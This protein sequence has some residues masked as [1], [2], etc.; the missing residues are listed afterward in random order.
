MA[1]KP[2]ETLR[3]RKVIPAA[4]ERVFKAWIDPAQVKK[5]WS[6]GEGW[7]TPVAEVDLRVGGRFS[8]GNEPSG[9]GVVLITG[10]FLAVDPPDKLVYTWRFPGARPEESRVTVEFNDLGEQTEVVVT[11]EEIG[12][13]MME[14]A[15][16][17]W[18]DALE[19]LGRFVADRS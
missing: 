11:H 7:K 4:R 17:G 15:V 5:W 14:G 9:G 10:E 19:N 1:E 16:S 18:Q 3:I 12:Q 6:L 2:P 8:I 13:E